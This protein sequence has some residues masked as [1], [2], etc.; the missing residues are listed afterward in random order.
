M[1]NT[2]T[3][4]KMKELRLFGMYDYFN[5]ALET[6]LI[7]D[8]K[9]DE[10][11][12]HLIDAEYND[13]SDKKVQRLIKNAGFRMIS[14][15]ENIKYKADRNLNKTQI[16]KICDLKWLKNGENIIITGFTGTGKTFISC[17]IGLKACMH[18]YKVSFFNCS[19]LFYEL[20]YSKS[21][22]NYLKMFEKLIKKDLIIID[23][24]GL[25]ILDKESRMFLFELLEERLCPFLTFTIQKPFFKGGSYAGNDVPIIKIVKAVPGDRWRLKKDEQRDSYQIIVNEQPLINSEGKY[26][27]IPESNIRMLK[28]YVKDY[29]VL[30]ENTYLILGNKA[31]GSLDATRFGLID[32]SDIMGKV[33]QD[34]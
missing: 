21:C 10:F 20:K 11:I 28:L 2:E 5:N 9:P 14:Q 33:E 12:A 23:D 27:Q 3:L 34:P 13:R 17:A 4:E 6:G 24:F 26:Y 15:V 31:S 7:H 16:L 30:P 32:K 19:K 29:P 25:D 18:E 8:F 22:G 1:N